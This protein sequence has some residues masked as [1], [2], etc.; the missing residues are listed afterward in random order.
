MPARRR[1]LTYKDAGVDRES[2]DELL[3][4]V[5]SRIRATFQEGVL[6]SGEEFGGL[7]ALRWYRDPVVVASIDGVGTKS[8]VAALCGRLRVVGED[9]VSHGANDVVCQGATPLFML[10]YV[11]S[12]QLGPAVAEVIE[13]VADACQAQ[14]IALLGGETAE[15]PGVYA[16][17]EVDVV[18]CTVG[19]AERSQVI[20]GERVAPGDVIVG[21]A[22]SGLHTNG[23][24]LARAVLLPASGRA[25]Q[26][27]AL[28]RRP[29]GL[30]ETL[31]E[32][33]LRP[34]RPYARAVLRLRESVPLHGIA[35]VT[36]GGIPANLSRVLPDGCRAVVWRGRWRVPPIFGLIQRR[37]MVSD[38]EM[39]RTFNM[40]LGML[41][42]VPR[43]AAPAAVAT[44]EAAGEQVWIV[45]E[46]I[47]GLR[48]VEIR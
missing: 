1:S 35:H 20:T 12:A 11:A 18:G 43:D 38:D 7:F 44:L 4:R 46:V 10:D 34:H 28:L 19:A 5:R 47:P 24:S 6:G 13:G 16:R 29:R 37:G 23:Y 27:R 40:G 33:L 25:D 30:S 42:V 41:V 14:G 31:E 2:R 17:G 8:T 32:A 26:A 22:S 48:E 21:L 39:F 36:G 3:A 9:V 45:G 15:M